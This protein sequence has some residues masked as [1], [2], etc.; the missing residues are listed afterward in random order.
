M[1]PE[2][3]VDGLFKEVFATPGYQLTIDLQA[4]SITKPDGSSIAFD[5]L[6][7]RRHCLLNGLDD[8][9]LTLRHKDEIAAFEAKRL[10]EKP[11]MAHTVPMAPQINA[12]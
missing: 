2:E 1:L 12:A 10:A 6:P 4:Q 9:G 3:T 5:V 8:I 7:F 11:W